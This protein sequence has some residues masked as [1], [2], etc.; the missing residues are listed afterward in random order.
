MPI[1]IKDESKAEYYHVLHEAQINGNYGPIN[2]Y[3]KKEQLICEK[4]LV[5]FITEKLT[6]SKSEDRTTLV[7]NL[8]QEMLQD[9]LGMD[10]ER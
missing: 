1:I 3:A 6:R 7:S 8:K 2:E 5:P 9:G 4:E 10:I